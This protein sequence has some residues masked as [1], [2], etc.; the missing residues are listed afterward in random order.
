MSFFNKVL[1]SVGIGAAKVDTILPKGSYV[2]GEKI[3]GVVEIK[4]GNVE[5]PIDEIYLSLLTQYTKKS[6]D[7]EYVQTAVIA[8]YRVSEKHIIAPNEKKEIPFSIALPLS[9]PL[10]QGKTRVWIQTG[11]DIKNAI[12][13][14]DKDFIE[15]LPLPVMKAVISSVQELGFRTREIECQEAPR[16]LRGVQSF[17]QEFEFVPVSGAYRGKLD[18]LEIV[19]V[20]KSESEVDLY[21]QID[22]KARGLGGFLSEA[23]EMD[24]RNVKVTV[25]QAD[26]SSMTR[27]LDEVI[28]RYS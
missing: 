6:D 15:V 23:L 12:D 8:K 7:K 25:S 5:Q 26:L 21:L 4:G 3:N 2:I 18:E 10:S 17:V 16:Y 20:V 24:E 11:L 9:A 27:K 13:P 1:A 14:T 28:R 22:R 19:F